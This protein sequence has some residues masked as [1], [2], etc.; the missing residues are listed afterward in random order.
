MRK[1][2]I[3]GLEWCFKVGLVIAAAGWTWCVVYAGINDDM[4]GGFWYLTHVSL[5]GVAL[6]M[7]PMVLITILEH[8]R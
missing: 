2:I 4:D 7:W 5:I 1:R 3:T 8:N 6:C